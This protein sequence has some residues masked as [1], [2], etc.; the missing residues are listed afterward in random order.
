[1]NWFCMDMSPNDKW[2]ILMQKQRKSSLKDQPQ[3]CFYFYVVLLEIH[4]LIT[5]WYLPEDQGHSTS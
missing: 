3:T 5:I 4:L 1:M 2:N